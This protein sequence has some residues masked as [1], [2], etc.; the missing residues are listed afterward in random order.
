MKTYVSKVTSD[1]T[2]QLLDNGNQHKDISSLIN[3][4]QSSCMILK[5]K[6][7][8]LILEASKLWKR[9]NVKVF[10]AVFVWVTNVLYL[11]K[12]NKCW[13]NPKQNP[14]TLRIKKIIN[15]LSYP[16]Y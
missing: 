14:L 1:L 4:I 12:P 6:I 9:E 10:L 15:I 2:S 16:F 11:P 7:I 13:I 8:I 5:S 3:K